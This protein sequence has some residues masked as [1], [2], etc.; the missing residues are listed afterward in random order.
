[1]AKEILSPDEYQNRLVDFYEQTLGSA[2]IQTTNPDEEEDKKTEYVAPKI[3]DD[4][5]DDD[6]DV[7]LFAGIGRDAGV[8]SKNIDSVLDFKTNNKTLDIMELNLPSSYS[9]HL[10]RNNR[11]NK[12]D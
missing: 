5:S 10:E 7:N 8:K 2:G 1:M 9:Q 4:G 11:N 6:G 3:I 12:S